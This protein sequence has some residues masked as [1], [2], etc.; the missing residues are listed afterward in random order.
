MCEYIFNNG[1]KC[2]EDALEGSK[3]CILH[4]PFPKN[5]NSKEFKRIAKLKEQKVKEKISKGDF[6]FEGAKLLKVDF[7]NLEIKG[8]VNFINAVI[9]EDTSFDGAKIEGKVSFG[10]AKIK[11]NAW[12]E[13]ATIEGSVSFHEAK[14]KGKVSFYKATI[15]WDVQ[16]EGATIKGDVWFN[17]ATIGWDV[18]FEGATIKGNAQFDEAT[19]GWDVQFEGATIKGDVWFELATIKGNAW[20]DEAT[21]EGHAL[22]APLDIK[23]ELSF[24]NTKFITNNEVNKERVSKTLVNLEAE[25]EACQAAVRA[26]EKLGDRE[27]ADYHFYREM[28]ARRKQKNK[29]TQ[30]FEWLLADFTCQYGTDFIRPIAIWFI[31]VL[32]VF[33]L[34][35]YFGHGIIS[36]NPFFPF[37]QGAAGNAK[38]FLSAEYFSIVT[39]TTLG[40]GDLQPALTTI[41]LFHIQVPI[42]R[43]LASIEAIFG[44]F[45]WVIF[46][47]VFARKYM[48]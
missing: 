8:D 23:G 29:I 27:G 31:L 28:R 3:Y 6:N 24:G 38:S 18:Q 11:G 2:K 7:S 19:I 46:L 33:P 34:I 47:T 21:I 48:R 36:S 16:F 43:L 4:M 32:V 10:G 37:F 39:A 42:F 20:F 14:I 25:E 5:R 9:L 40:Y 45:M 26:L 13:G 17:E 1:K 44:T 22:F 35:Y 12:F 15:G 30:F 41:T